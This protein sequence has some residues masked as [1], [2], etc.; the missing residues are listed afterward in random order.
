MVQKSSPHAS[1]R[2]THL[3]VLQRPAQDDLRGV[4]AGLVGDAVYDG[5]GQHRI[6]IHAPHQ[7]LR[8]QRAVSLQQRRHGVIV[9]SVFFALSRQY[10]VV[11]SK[12]L[13]SFSCV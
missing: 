6:L 1:L 5:V 8:P 12:F 9:L 3:A 2:V 4:A 7:P 10:K 13:L 11:C